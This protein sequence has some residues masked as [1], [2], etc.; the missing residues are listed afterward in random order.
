M[1]EDFNKVLQRKRR[2]R[3]EASSSASS[4]SLVWTERASS[5]IIVDKVEP[6]WLSLI[7]EVGVGVGDVLSTM[8]AAIKR[9][10]KEDTGHQ[11]QE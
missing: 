7:E 4:R 8:P 5:V 2:T 3:R 10:S 11:K 9:P 6:A 1:K